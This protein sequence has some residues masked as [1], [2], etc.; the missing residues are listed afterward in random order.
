MLTLLFFMFTMLD[1]IWIKRFMKDFTYPTTFVWMCL[2]LLS[3]FDVES[4][5]RFIL[6]LLLWLA[7]ID[8]RYHHVS[9]LS[10]IL[11]YVVSFFSIPPTLHTFFYLNLIYVFPFVFLSFC[12]ERMGWGDTHIVIACSL[13]LDHAAFS[14]WILLFTSLALVVG[15]MHK[16]TKTMIALVPFMAVSYVLVLILDIV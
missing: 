12:K 15:L 5:Y 1:T 11:L 13:V 10:L 4:S 2:V 14:V 7:L 9:D 3:V 6:A 16:K 8:Y